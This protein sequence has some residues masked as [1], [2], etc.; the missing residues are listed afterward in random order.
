MKTFN[1]KVSTFY[2]LL[3]FLLTFLTNLLTFS[4]LI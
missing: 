2:I 1:I 4:G 3:R